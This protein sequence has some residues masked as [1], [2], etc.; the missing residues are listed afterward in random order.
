MNLS[1]FFVSIFKKTV[2][3]KTAKASYQKRHRAADSL[4]KNFCKK[5]E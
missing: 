1:V 3:S 5:G 4:L 2:W